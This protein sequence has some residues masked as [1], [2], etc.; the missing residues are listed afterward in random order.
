MF[1]RIE[2]MKEFTFNRTN[3]ELKPHHT[4][5]DSRRRVPFNR[6]NMELKL[7]IVYQHYLHDTLLIAPI[8]N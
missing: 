2:S 7:L 8:W 6:T 3:M 5:C 1:L 4:A